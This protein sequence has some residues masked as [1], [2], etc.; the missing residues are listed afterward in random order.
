VVV[1]SPTDATA[2]NIISGN[3]TSGISLGGTPSSGN[4]PQVNGNIIGL[5]ASG[6]AALPSLSFGILVTHAASSLTLGADG[7]TA[8]QLISGNGSSGIR[9][10]SSQQVHLGSSNYI[11][12]GADHVTPLGNSG[13]GVGIGGSTS[14]TV[15][16][17]VIAHNGGGVTVAGDSSS[18]ILIR[19]G[20]VHGN[21]WTAVDLI[22]TSGFDANDP[23]DT[24]TGPNTLLNYPEITSAEGNNVPGTA[25]LGCFV[26]I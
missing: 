5:N 12:V 11:G 15:T 18:G 8:D 9:I 13:D 19:P 1:G 14:S 20:D 25:C 6:T 4:A 23:G 7:A 21:G 16:P 22:G 2:R 17:A 24:D 10:Q 26:F 3:G